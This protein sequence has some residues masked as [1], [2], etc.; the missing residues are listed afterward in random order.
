MCCWRLLCSK[1]LKYSSSFCELQC[2]HTYTYPYSKLLALT[3]LLTF[4]RIYWV[5]NVL[6][7][8]T[9]K[10]SH[11][12]TIMSVLIT[13]HKFI[14][15]YLLM[16]PWRCHLELRSAETNN[17]HS[18]YILHHRDDRKFVETELQNR[19]RKCEKLKE[20][21]YRDL[22]PQHVHTKCRSCLISLIE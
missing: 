1:I 11:L 5:E 12:H 17:G 22:P 18:I 21:L 19:H 3:Y 8:I 14:W 7:I 16:L 13:F 4:P 10:P 2:C 20:L 15:Y 6:V 9:Y